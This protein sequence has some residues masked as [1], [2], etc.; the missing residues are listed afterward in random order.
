MLKKVIIFMILSMTIMGQGLKD[1][2]YSVQTDKSIWFWYPKTEIIVKN[3]QVINVSHDRVKKDGRLASKDEWY[4]K[5]MLKKTG[6]NPENY[7]K[8][9]PENYFKADK[10]LKTMDNVAGASESVIHFKKQM[11]FLLEKAKKGETGSFEISKKDLK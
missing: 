3:G 10:N 5:K 1:G 6:S 9:I 7:S 11:E 8:E 2:E 4:N